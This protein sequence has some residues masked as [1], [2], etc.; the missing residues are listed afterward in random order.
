CILGAVLVSAAACARAITVEEATRVGGDLTVAARKLA[1]LRDSGEKVVA[2]APGARRELVGALARITDAAG[3]RTFAKQ[4]ALL[5]LSLAIL[6]ALVQ[7]WRRLTRRYQLVFRSDALHARGALGQLALD[8]AERVAVAAAA[9]LLIETWFQAA[10]PQ[11][12]L[13]IAVLW[14][15][16]RWWFAMLLIEALLRPR[17]PAFRLIAMSDAAA[18]EVK[19]I[20]AVTLMIGFAGIAVMPVL[21][22]AA[23]PIPAGQVIALLQGAL[24]AAGCALALWRY[25]ASHS[26]PVRSARLWTGFG[27]TAI[28][29]LWVAWSLAV[30][31]LEF[32]TYHAF[33]WSMRIGALAYLV[34]ALLGLSAQ[35]RWLLLVQRS[36]TA[37]ALLAIAILLAETW[38]VDELKLVAAET[39]SA[40][41]T[42][43]VSAALTLLAGYVAWRYLHQW[44]EARLRAPAPG[45]AGEPPQAAS[46]LT[47]VLPMLRILAGT[48]ILV[49]TLL[50]ALSQL[51]V[52]I[53]PLLAGAGVVGLAIS[54]GAQTLVKDVITGA[55]FLVDDAFR[56]GEYIVSGNYKGQVE[57][58]TLRSVRL[59]HHRGSVYTVPFG[60]L[61]AIQNMS[62]DWVIDKFS[63]GITYDSDIEK[64]RKLIKQVG[65]TLA[66]DPAHAPHILEPL[67]MQGVEQFGDFAVQVRIKMKTRPGQ[68]FVIRRKANAMIK[69]AFD[70][71]GVKFA[72]PTVQVA[73]GSGGEGIAAAAKQSL[74]PA[75]PPPS[76]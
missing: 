45:A 64:A 43:L 53:T 70:A 4:A 31:V 71:N 39:W 74:A 25:R 47:T 72:F 18:R 27:A 15:A 20:V 59:R 36:I 55:F 17:T 58:I 11:D 22:R 30:L 14:A 54:F 32:S 61:R 7:A 52:Q 8:A 68:Q 48:A 75:Q 1:V 13:A 6:G 35:A 57:A 28:L 49:V 37:A 2:A 69:K 73:G 62:R 12:L 66:A 26:A 56:V 3:T 29:G 10:T 5:A 16:V 24:V 38:L 60:E 23:L 33:T 19:A 40:L 50:L 44:T 46:R 34:H 41:R 9:Y 51:G 67:K 21:L 63:V 76:S 65:Q 42:S